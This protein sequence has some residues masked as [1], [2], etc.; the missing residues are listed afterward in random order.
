MAAGSAAAT[1]AD[2]TDTAAADDIDTDIDIETALRE[3][4]EAGRLFKPRLEKTPGF[5]IREDAPQ[6]GG[7]AQGKMHRIIDSFI[8]S[9]GYLYVAYRLTSDKNSSDV[10]RQGFTRFV[11]LLPLPKE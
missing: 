3:R 7:K 4:S 11:K 9:D 2:D 6:R 8:S 10:G 5:Y 1:A